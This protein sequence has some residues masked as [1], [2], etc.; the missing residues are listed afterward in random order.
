MS[1]P[2]VM[3]RF[4]GEA[5]AL[6]RLRHPRIVPIY[7][8]GRCG[9]QYY[10]AMALIEGRSLAE[11]LEEETPPCRRSAEIAAELAEALAYAHGLGIIH[12]D[13]KPANIRLDARGAS[14]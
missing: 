6:A 1:T 2:R 11:A 5:R 4:L 13:V 14:I 7:E 9:D 10:I 12:R 3:E 8:A